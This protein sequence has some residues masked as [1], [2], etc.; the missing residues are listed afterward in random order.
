[1]TKSNYSIPPVPEPEDV[2]VEC[3]VCHGTGKLTGNYRSVTCPN[4]AGAGTETALLLLFRAEKASAEES[5]DHLLLTLGE[6]FRDRPL[7]GA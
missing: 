5:K 3:H 6:A 2:E 4:C 1:M 7:F